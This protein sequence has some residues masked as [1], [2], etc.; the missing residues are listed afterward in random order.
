[1][2]PALEDSCCW[3]AIKKS[4]LRPCRTGLPVKMHKIHKGIAILEVSEDADFPLSF[5][6]KWVKNTTFQTDISGTRKYTVNADFC[7]NS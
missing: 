1:M 4:G 7:H 6:V 2:L 3:C 5:M